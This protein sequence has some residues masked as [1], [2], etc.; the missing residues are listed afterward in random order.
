MLK[1]MEYLESLKRNHH[2]FKQ[3]WI[4][5][6]DIPSAQEKVKSVNAFGNLALGLWV[7]ICRC[8]ACAFLLERFR[9][10]LTK[11][12]HGWVMKSHGICPSLWT[13][14]CRYWDLSLLLCVWTANV[15]RTI[16][17]G[18]DRSWN[19]GGSAHI[20]WGKNT[21]IPGPVLTDNRGTINTL[22]V[23]I[24]KVHFATL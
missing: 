3:K 8:L 17:V 12:R 13:D 20:L 15:K 23:V 18:K 10:L 9:L 7:Y 4:N 21:K 1:Y 16:Q 5:Y 19:W 24:I 14:F 22:H 6:I 2:Y 11:A